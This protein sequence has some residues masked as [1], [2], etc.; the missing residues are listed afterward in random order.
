MRNIYIPKL[1]GTISVKLSFWGSYTLIIPPMGVKFG[2]EKW[3]FKP[4]VHS[5]MPNF[6][7]GGWL[8]FNV[9][10]Q[11]KCGYI[12]DERLWGGELSSYLVKEG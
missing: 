11:H 5:S 6:N 4:S 8:E 7:P 2:M 12:R 1:F 10:F 3:T 9:P